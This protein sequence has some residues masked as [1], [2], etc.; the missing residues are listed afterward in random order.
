MTNVL[1]ILVDTDAGVDDTLAMFVLMQSAPASTIDIAVTFGNVPLEQ[2]MSNVSLFS[3]ISGFPPRKVLRGSSG[4]LRGEPRFAADVHGVDGLGGITE[5]PQWRPP[6]PRLC[7]KLFDSTKLDIYDKV[8]TLGP[9]TDIAR[10]T[11]SSSASP[12]LFVMGGAFDVKG[13]I[14]PHAEFNFYS[15]P[16]AASNLLQGYDRDAFIVPLDVCNHVVLG[17]KYFG[18]LCDKNGTSTAAFLKLIHQH[19]MDF[20]QRI[21]G[22]MAAIHTTRWRSLL[23]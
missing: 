22:S 3:A 6:P 4:P 10:L 17:R 14:S 7:A 9:L 1:Q 5:L 11:E 8:I 12:P 16:E 23:L 21:E 15:D 13:N 19:Y 20:Y 18:D 2:A